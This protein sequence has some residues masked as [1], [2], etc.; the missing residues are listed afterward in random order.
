MLGEQSN[1]SAF[2]SEIIQM[3]ISIVQQFVELSVLFVSV[4]LVHSLLNL[5]TYQQFST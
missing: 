4:D 1:A 3:A 2:C 5:T